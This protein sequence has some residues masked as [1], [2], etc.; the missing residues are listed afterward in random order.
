MESPL[1][2]I[3]TYYQ[4]CEIPCVS[5]RQPK[6]AALLEGALDSFVF[7]HK[8]PKGSDVFIHVSRKYEEKDRQ[9][10]WKWRSK[11][12][13]LTPESKFLYGGLVAW[14]RVIDRSQ[15][16]RTQDGWVFTYTI[17]NMVKLPFHEI[18]GSARVFWEENPYTKRELEGKPLTL[19]IRK[20]EA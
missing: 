4:G 16:K 10:Y 3:S 11:G 20:V 5:I 18:G 1:G 8:I 19:K 14:V 9:R 17:G 7:G 15:S 6:A 13:L 12:F 2:T